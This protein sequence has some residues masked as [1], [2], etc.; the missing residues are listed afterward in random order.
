MLLFWR[1]GYEGTSLAELTAAMGVTPP[2][3]YAAFGDKKRLFLEAVG[4]YL[5]GPPGSEGPDWEHGP[6]RAIVER[7]LRAAAARYTGADTP[8]GCLVAS[9]AITG[10]P[11]AAEVR[12]ALA[13]VRLD[14]EAR[15]R[16][17]IERAAASGELPADTD[18]DAL[19]GHVMA[20]V[21]GMST[22]A[23]D[24]ATRDKLLR[25]AAAAMRGWP[26]RAGG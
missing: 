26:D 22:L 25:V 18:A 7:L 2:S 8:A 6:A 11:A 10:S 19:A 1:H 13:A 14:T 9:A 20:V 12:A 17:L 4:R 15:L 16:G 24:G 21:Q 3:V 23:R 5:D